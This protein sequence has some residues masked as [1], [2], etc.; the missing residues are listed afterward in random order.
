MSNACPVCTH[1]S[2]GD[3]AAIVRART[4]RELIADLRNMHPSIDA[5]QAATDFAQTYES[6][7]ARA[8]ALEND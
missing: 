8:D 3:C 2:H 7:L 5:A 1:H 6:E 4:I